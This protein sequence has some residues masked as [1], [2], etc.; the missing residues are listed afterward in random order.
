MFNKRIRLTLGIQKT[1]D[2][3]QLCLTVEANG[4]LP[5]YVSHQNGMVKVGGVAKWYNALPSMYKALF[6]PQM[7]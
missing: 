4:L 3:E 5:L 7:I 6:G 2:K 1:E